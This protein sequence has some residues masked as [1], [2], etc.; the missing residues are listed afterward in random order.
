MTLIDAP[1]ILA[2]PRHKDLQ[3]L[4]AREIAARIAARELSSAEVVEHF[5][6]RLKS[7]NGK[8]N[9]VTA[10]LSESAR[11]AAEDVDN[12]AL[13]AMA[14]IEAAARTQPGYPT[15]PPL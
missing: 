10:D 1:A 3:N 14:A 13:A 5:V 11:K 2:T 4:S 9:A 6:A 8:L 12:V 15:E 7:V